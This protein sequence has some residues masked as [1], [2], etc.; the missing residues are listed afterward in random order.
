MVRAEATANGVPLAMSSY[1]HVKDATAYPQRRLPILF[2]SLSSNTSEVRLQLPA[3]RTLKK[4]PA[5]RT[6]NG[7]GVSAT[8]QFQLVKE[9]DR[10]VL[11]VKRSLTLSRR[12]IPAT[13]QLHPKGI[14]LLHDGSG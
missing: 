4:V 7:P 3:G 14:H 1:H 11:V 2:S 13:D 6:L 10:Q 9:Q 12:E 5:D 8:S